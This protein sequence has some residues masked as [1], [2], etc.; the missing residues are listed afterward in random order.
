V[1]GYHINDMEARP[2]DIFLWRLA[3]NNEKDEYTIALLR[4][5]LE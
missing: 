1:Q 3:E 2:T 5:R 4:R